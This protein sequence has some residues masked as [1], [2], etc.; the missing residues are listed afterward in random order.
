MPSDSVLRQTTL[1]LCSVLLLA[2]CAVG[3]ASGPD[4]TAPSQAASARIANPTVP[5]GLDVVVEDYEGS[6]TDIRTVTVTRED[7]EEIPSAFDLE[8]QAA[9]EASLEELHDQGSGPQQPLL[10]LNPYGTSTTGLYTRFTTDGDGVLEY[11]VSSAGTEDFTRTAVD[12][13]EDSGVFN[14]QLIG[15]VPGA[16]NAVTTTWR[17]EAG[18][19]VEHTFTVT[20]PESEAGYPT[21]LERTVAGDPEQLTD[22]LFLLSGLYQ[23][24]RYGFLFDNAGTMRAELPIDGHMLDRFETYGNT[25]VYPT[26]DSVLSR[27]DG[28]GRV[29]EIYDLGPFAM[30]H[31]FALTDD[32]RA[33]ILASDTSRESIEDVLLSLDLATGEYEEVVDFTELLAGYK[34][35][36]DPYEAPNSDGEI[37]DDWL[38]LNSVDVHDGE[39]SVVVSGRENSTII[40]VGDVHGE[41]VLE[42]L[43]GVDELWEGSGHEEALLEKV[44]DFSD[45]GGQH[46]V[47]RHEDDT[48]ADGQHYLSIFDNAYWRI[49]SRDDY[50][51]PVPEDTSTVQGTDPEE[52]SYIRTYLVDENERTYTQ[53]ESLEVPYSAIV[54]SA[55]HVGDNTVV[56][57]GQAFVLTEY[58]ANDEAIATY[59]YEGE[60]YAYRGQKYSFDEFWYTS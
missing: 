33:L 7:T 49:L 44:G 51:G 32:G 59:A 52:R 19:P 16:Q 11:T 27:V 18:E 1:G 45:T 8:V 43:I 6:D 36:T 35:L 9:V 5:P 31:D 2:G 48:L 53:V 54:S 10:V 21:Q 50:T 23:P 26:D 22:G 46:T 60:R 56:N 25:L 24:G 47:V 29:V 39:D 38:H 4:Q 14:G 58:D 57:S 42:Y 20:A 41:P 55:Q 37:V 17:P 13:D 30:H 12:H 34:D 3:D 28:L 15:L 40:K